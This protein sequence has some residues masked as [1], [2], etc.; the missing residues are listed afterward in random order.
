MALDEALLLRHDAG[1]TLRLYRWS[2]PAVSLGYHQRWARAYDAG[3]AAELGL[4]VVRR[5]TG[6]RA[7]LHDDELTYSF[8]GPTDHPRLQGGVLAAYRALAVGLAEG[9]RR[10]GV[11][12]ELE[13]TRARR[14]AGRSGDLACFAVRS[15]YELVA[16]DR[17]LAGSAQRRRDG[18]LLQH[19]SLLLGPPDPRRWKALG[20]GASEALT[21]SVGLEEL[22]GRRPGLRRLAGSL[23]RQ[24][25]DSLGLQLRAG[26]LTRLERRTARRCLQRYASPGWTRKR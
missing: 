23:G 15:R 14:G 2:R 17:K 3:R 21:A 10:L 5:P 12:V 8:T 20:P 6:G 16:G 1:Y 11:D 24:V 13:R 9:L 26:E 25:A 19:G 7:V 4:S 22:L 18:R